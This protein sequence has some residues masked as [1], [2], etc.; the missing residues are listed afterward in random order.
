MVQAG[1]HNAHKAEMVG[2][3]EASPSQSKALT[4]DIKTKQ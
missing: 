4:Q 3:F 2:K 1:E